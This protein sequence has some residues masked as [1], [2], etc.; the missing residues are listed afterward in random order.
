MCSTQTQTEH[1]RERII[2]SCESVSVEL[3]L[4]LSFCEGVLRKH[5]LCAKL[6]FHLSP[7]TPS[8]PLN[9]RALLYVENE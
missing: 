3:I 2:E 1:E 6:T 4:V 9:A 8:T 5:K 7:E